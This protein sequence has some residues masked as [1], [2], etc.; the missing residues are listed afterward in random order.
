MFLTIFANSGIKSQ[1]L[2]LDCEKN[3]DWCYLHVCYVLASINFIIIEL[4]YRVGQ[5]LKVRQGKASKI[6]RNINDK[7]N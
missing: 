4:I 2:G 7:K 3:V 5:K 6:S 1:A